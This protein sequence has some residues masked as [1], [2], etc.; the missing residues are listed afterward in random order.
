[1]NV[2]SLQKNITREGVSIVAMTKCYNHECERDA[3]E[4]VIPLSKA[5]LF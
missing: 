3:I 1:M 4:I 2:I 5:L